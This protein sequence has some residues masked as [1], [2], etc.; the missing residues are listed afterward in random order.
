MSI[1]ALAVEDCGNLVW[2]WIGDHKEYDRLIKQALIQNSIPTFFWIEKFGQSDS[3]REFLQARE[4]R[5]EQLA[6]STWFEMP[7][8]PNVEG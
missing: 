8:G 2:F 1:R 5:G 4:D 7:R 3:G 6:S